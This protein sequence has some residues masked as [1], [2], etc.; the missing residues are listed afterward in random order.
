[1][2][3]FYYCA[4]RLTVFS[5]VLLGMVVCKSDMASCQRP[6]EWRPS[7]AAF[8]ACRPVRHLYRDEQRRSKRLRSPS[9]V[10]LLSPGPAGAFTG[11][12]PRPLSHDAPSLA[13]SESRYSDRDCTRQ[14]HRRTNKQRQK[15]KKRARQVS[16]LARISD[17]AVP[18]PLF[19]G[20]LGRRVC[21]RHTV[22]ED[23][24]VSRLY[25]RGRFWHGCSY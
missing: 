18:P 6:V 9:Q 2:G 5:G 10:P 15:Q 24:H 12:G 11:R 19:R 3:P 20:T 21:R 25:I 1:V 17:H 8:E 7:E 16:L 23:K 4:C 14:R 13:T 22:G